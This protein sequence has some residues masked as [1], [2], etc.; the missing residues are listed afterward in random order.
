[1]SKVINLHKIFDHNDYYNGESLN[2]SY[3]T[4][5]SAIENDIFTGL[6]K[7]LALLTAFMVTELARNYKSPK[8]SCLADCDRDPC[9]AEYKSDS[10]FISLE[11]GAPKRKL[12]NRTHFHNEIL[13]GFFKYKEYEDLYGIPHSTVNSWI[14]R[15]ELYLDKSIHYMYTG[16]KPSRGAVFNPLNLFNKLIKI[17]K[18]KGNFPIKVHYYQNLYEQCIAHM[19]KEISC[20]STT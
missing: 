2:E 4:L 20:K 18:N 12:Q 16:K 11:G 5:C 19:N 13:P 10:K 9:A 17:Y 14:M 15:N 8:K 1:M 3:K 6:G 7:P